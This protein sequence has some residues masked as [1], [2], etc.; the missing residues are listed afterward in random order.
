MIK[1]QLP[2]DRACGSA[3]VLQHVERSRT[4][5]LS[6]GP[7]LPGDRG[8]MHA[9]LLTYVALTCSRPICAKRSC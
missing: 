5:R 7:V 4:H 2:E 9:L 3:R 1:P 6:A 8:A